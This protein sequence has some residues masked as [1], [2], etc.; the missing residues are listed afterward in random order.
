MTF[1]LGGKRPEEFGLIVKADTQEPAMPEIRNKIVTVAGRHGALDFGGELGPRPFEISCTIKGHSAGEVQASI[2]LLMAHLLDG[3]GKPRTLPFQW[4][5]EQGMVYDV[6]LSSNVPVDKLARLGSFKLPLTA[7][8]PFAYSPK[9]TL[10][11]QNITL[12]DEIPLISPY[13]LD[14]DTNYTYSVTGNT[15]V[16][17]GNAGTMNAEP[18]ITV[19]GSFTTLSITVNG[20]TFSYN[21]AVSSKTLIVNS[22]DFTVTENGVNALGDSNNVFLK[23]I[24]GENVVSINGTGLSCTISFDFKHKYI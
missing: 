1:T 12:D 3:D 7:Y 5:Y 16:N 14:Y 2:R 11:M 9:T 15:T 6:R 18:K 13:D 8:D 23:L 10:E 17:I 24:P 4:D 21:K 20:K 22:K 19:T